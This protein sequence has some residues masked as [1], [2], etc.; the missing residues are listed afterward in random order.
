M[1]HQQIT[2]SFKIRGATNAMLQLTETQKA[3]GVVCVSSGNHGR[4]IA[5]AAKRIGVAAKVFMSPF[6]PDIK[7]NGIRDLGAEVIIAGNNAD[8]AEAVAIEHI[9]RTGIHLS[10]P[11]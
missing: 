11:F 2:N 3:A 5:L 9:E 10:A 1:E 7:V 6:V 4:G 8:D